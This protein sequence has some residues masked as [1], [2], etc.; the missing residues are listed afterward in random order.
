MGRM[1]W[2]LAA[3]AGGLLV[4][5]QGTVTP[6][7]RPADAPPGVFS[8]GRAMRDIEVIA[9]IPHPIGSPANAAARDY[10]VG[11]MAAMGLTPRVQAGEAFFK[12]DRFKGETYVLGAMAQNIVGVLPGQDPKAP[13][14]LL[15]AH[16]DSVPGSPG[17]A[18]DATGVASAL[19]VVRI[20]KAQGT[21]ARDVIVLLTDGEEAGLLGA[22]AFFDQDPLAGRVGLVINM[23]SRGGG[24]R[25]NMF[26]TGTRNGE[27]IR[28][29]ADSPSKPISSSL[30]VFL[31]EHMPND[32]DFTVSKAA[33]ISGYNFAFIGRQFDYHSPSSTPANLDQGSVQS[34]GDQVLTLA[35]ALA[36]AKALPGPAPDWT[37]SQTFGNHVWGY[38]TWLGWLLLAAIA[39]MLVLAT[40]PHR[41][42]GV[43]PLAVAKSVGG[44]LYMILATALLLHLMRRATGVAFGFL[45]M[46]PLLAQWNLYEAALAL[47][48]VGVA[49]HAASTL[50]HG[51][52]VRW[53]VAAPIAGGLICSLFGGWDLFGLGLGLATAILSVSYLGKPPPLASAWLGA[54]ILAFLAALG[55]QIAAPTTAFLV[56]WPLLGGAFMAANGA[57]GSRST[58]IIRFGE[59]VLGAAGIGWLGV[60]FH[61]LAQGLDLPEILALFGWLGLVLVWP[62][63]HRAGRWPGPVFITLGVALIVAV[64]LHSP[65]TERYPQVS[66]VAHLTELD[67]GKAWR[68]ALS[69]GLDDWTR[70]A[71]TGG[72]GKIEPHA[73]PTMSKD[74]LNAAPAEKVE[75]LAPTL[76]ITRQADGQVAVR[77]TPP[78][79]A[80]QFALDLS[81][82][83]PVSDVRLDGKPAPLLDKPKAR[84]HLIW[85]AGPGG[86]TLT[87]KPSGPGAL[88][89]DY[90]ALTEAWPAS[91]KPLPPR[92]EAQAPW[93]TSD[94]TIVTGS[95]KQ[96]W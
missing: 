30:A 22:R 69:P 85:S 37:Y 78:P 4:A 73:F 11:R 68:V 82:D 49:L 66:K 26:Q 13:A 71:L 93:D 56:T 80:R 86:V 48:T 9:K 77:F 67:S 29:L 1:F 45:E 34:M 83:V 44:T 60:Y 61:S 7:P 53:A 62:L 64:R 2:L 38:P 92:P 19:E 89:V 50:A 35:R 10:L 91:A 65:W 25:A 24:G 51:I 33:G 84:S 18:D 17:A 6:E 3:L 59:A 63:A 12:P 5:W 95:V 15:M 21:P 14:L 39:I 76:S 36:F 16:Y 20:L 43:A 41:K 42:I 90:R 72:G 8:A 57:L 75:A 54:L 94:S 27:L 79:G 88:S 70:T 58:P 47:M 23:E 74:P 28:L 52:K 81:A 87:F 46:R 40:R 32:T 31:Y 96:A 55:M